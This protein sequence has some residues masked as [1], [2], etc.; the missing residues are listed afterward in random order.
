MKTLIL[1]LCVLHMSGRVENRQMDVDYFS[2]SFDESL[3]CKHEDK[4]K[5]LNKIGQCAYISKGEYRASQRRG[6]PPQLKQN[7]KD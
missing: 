3:N 1:L 7:C 2:D 6:D 4:V 5:K